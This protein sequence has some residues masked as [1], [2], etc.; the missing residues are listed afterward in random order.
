MKK[1]ACIMLRRDE[2]KENG[3]FAHDTSVALAPSSSPYGLGAYNS[4]HTATPRSAQIVSFRNNFVCPRPLG[5]I[6]LGFMKNYNLKS[7]TNIHQIKEV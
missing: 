5:D 7:R 3:P 6:L 4:G 1:G 2:Q